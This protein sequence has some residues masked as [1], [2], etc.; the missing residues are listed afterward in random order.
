MTPTIIRARVQRVAI[1]VDISVLLEQLGVALRTLPILLAPVAAGVNHAPFHGLEQGRFGLWVWS[2]CPYCAV[3]LIRG[4]DFVTLF[5]ENQ[6]VSVG[7][8]S[9]L[10]L[11]HVDLGDCFAKKPVFVY[12]VDDGIFLHFKNP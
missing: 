1:V 3:N 4:S 2:A 6:Q 9:L 7:Q 10:E 5:E 12:V 8:S 11:D